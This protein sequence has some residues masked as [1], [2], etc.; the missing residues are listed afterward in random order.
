MLYNAGVESAVMIR[1]D[2]VG[3]EGRVGDATT[4]LCWVSEVCLGSIH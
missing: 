4:G 3:E 1:H 2:V